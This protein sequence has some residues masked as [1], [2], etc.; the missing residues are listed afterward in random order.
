MAAYTSSSYPIKVDGVLQAPVH[1]LN[2]KPAALQGLSRESI[3]L[4]DDG[5]SQVSEYSITFTPFS[6]ITKV[7]QASDPKK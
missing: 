3:A 6:Y 2:D 4:E 7:K 1:I 5:Y